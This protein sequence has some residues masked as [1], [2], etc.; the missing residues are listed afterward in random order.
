MGNNKM[1]HTLMFMMYADA[2]GNNITISP[3]LSSSHTEPSYTSNVTYTV[4]A[5]SGISN[6]V[7]TANVVCQNCRSW[8]GGSI[9]PTNTAAPFIFA[10]GPGGSLNTNSVSA[11]IKRHSIY[12]SFTLDLTKALGIG[13]MPYPATADSSGTVQDTDKTDHDFPAA[14]HACLMILAFVGLMPFGVFV[15]RV[16]NSPILHGWNQALSVAVALLGVVLGIYSATMYNRVC[17]PSNRARFTLT[18]FSRD[19]SILVIKFSV[20]SS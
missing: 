9:D 12:G 13:Q 3:R 8:E 6:G 2:T 10:A 7:M 5:G 18:I 19:I 11:D 15:L 17:S 14:F 20:F 16:L 1:D 4:E